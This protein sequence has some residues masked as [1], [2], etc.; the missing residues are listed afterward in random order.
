MYL[1]RKTVLKTPVRI[2]FDPSNEDHLK[3]YALFVKTSNWKNGCKYFLED[4]YQDIPSMIN[5]KV[6]GHFLESYV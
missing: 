5:A 2:S 6:V 1:Y 3:D 4:P